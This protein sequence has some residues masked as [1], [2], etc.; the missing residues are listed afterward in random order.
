MYY[1]PKSLSSPSRFSNVANE[2]QKTT[3]RQRRVRCYTCK[4]SQRGRDGICKNLTNNTCPYGYQIEPYL[5][6]EK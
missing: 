6:E 3:K 5:V 1:N 4:N 2:D